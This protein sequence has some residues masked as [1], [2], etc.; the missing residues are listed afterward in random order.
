MP[1]TRRELEAVAGHLCDLARGLT[2]HRG[3]TG[4]HWIMVS[5]VHDALGRHGI[6]LDDADLQAAIA[7]A[8]ERHVMKAEGKPVHSITPWQKDWDIKR[9]E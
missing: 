4:P 7:I 6:A 5:T 9:R 1:A 2:S 3:G 8:V